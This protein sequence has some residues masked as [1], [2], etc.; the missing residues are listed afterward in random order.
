MTYPLWKAMEF[1]PI[2]QHVLFIP[3][4]DPY[5]LCI[6]YIITNCRFLYFYISIPRSICMYNIC[7]YHAIYIYT[8]IYIYIYM[9]IHIYIYTYIYMGSCTCG[10]RAG[11]QMLKTHRVAAPG[12]ANAGYKWRLWWKDPRKKHG[13][14][15]LVTAC[16]KIHCLVRWFSQL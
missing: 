9:I 5:L 4:Q 11:L 10:E 15:Q 6:L 13:N 14:F 16:W 8:H 2:A 12:W 7:I 3:R 1:R